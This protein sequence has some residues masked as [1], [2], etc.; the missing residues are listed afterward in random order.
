M[1]KK[2]K[3][4]MGLIALILYSGIEPFSIDL[5]NLIINII[6]LWN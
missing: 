5:L 2:N 6:E 3:N 1:V 4:K